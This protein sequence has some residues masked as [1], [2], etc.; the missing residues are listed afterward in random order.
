M[1]PLSQ[2]GLGAVVAQI[3]GHR[4]LGFKAALLGAGAGALPD[5]DVLFS[6]TGDFIDQ[7][8][9]HR[10]ITHSLFFAPVTGPA[11]GWL[12]WYRERR[13][14]PSLSLSRRNCW[15]LVITLAL[16]SHPLLDWLTPYGTQLLL[17]LSNSRFA[18]NAMPIIDPV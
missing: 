10:G 9:T 11:L 5:A 12:I 6:I 15:M 2:A 4:R 16:L 8:I 13:K 18:I 17:P 14:D 1:D 7:L 3:A